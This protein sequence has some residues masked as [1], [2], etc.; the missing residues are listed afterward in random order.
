[1]EKQKKS[2]FMGKS[3]RINLTT[4]EIKEVDYTDQ[5]RDWLGALAIK[6]L[7]DELPEWVTPYDPKNLIIITSG[8]LI[9]TTAPGACKLNTSTLGPITGG[10]ATGS[11]DSY[12]GVELKQA[13]YDH[14]IIEGRAHEPCYLWVTDK[15][16]EIRDA[17]A[18]W[19]KTTWDTLDS[20][21]EE[22]QDPKLHVLSIGPA[23]E[24]MTRSACL[25]QDRG[26]AIGR[27]GQGAVWGSKNLKALVCKGM[28]KV[29]LADGDRFNK[30]V[31]EV[32]ARIR[33]T[34]NPN[35][36]YFRKYGSLGANYIVKQNACGIAYK[37]FQEGCWPDDIYPKL[38]MR[39][40]IDKFEV[41]GQGFPGCAVI[42]GRHLKITE[43][44]YAPLES[45]ANQWEVMGGLMARCCVTEPTFAVK[46]QAVCHQLGLDVDGPS[47]AVSWA[48]ECYD[49][50]I[51]T[52][53][54]TDGIDLTW[55]NEAAI[56]ELARKMAYREGFGNILAEGSL[57]A[58]SIIGRGSE[59]YAIHVK[60]QDL[61]ETVR[62]TNGW[63]LGTLVSTRGGAHT[64]GAVWWELISDKITDEDALEL[65]GIPNFSK[66]RIPTSYEGTVDMVLYNEILHRVCNSTGVCLY[67]TVMQSFE[68]TNLHDFA[69]LLSA[70]TGDEYTVKDL[71]DIAT[72]Q[73]N[74]EKAFNLKFTE[75]ARQDDIPQPRHFE[76]IPTGKS[77]GWQLERAEWDK[78]LDEY[79]EKHGWDKKTSYPKRETLEKYGLI[80]AARDMESIGKL[81]G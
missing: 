13:G 68:F 40:I 74:L 8:A 4:K 31:K 16:V 64:T 58:A 41:S 39:P 73:L 65:F 30:R 76:P 50:G 28:K 57:R 26:R 5:Y 49:R 56:L 67:N 59:E 52:K 15:G 9:G 6:I 62:G 51:L 25:V 81:G 79:Y 69:E 24:N 47:G 32:R 43:G 72:R 10:W 18:L 3:L 78:M 21:R 61:Y 12:V 19:G 7:Y 37:N 75:F 38:D 29:N 63:G 77:A 33:N 55:G 71:E 22:L 11:T 66:A 1:M 54:D 23:G 34:E 70:A 45:E 20:I 48:M 46:Y 44:P 80:K 2:S 35:V 14:I 42:C 53:E 17:S 60:K 36:E 27:C